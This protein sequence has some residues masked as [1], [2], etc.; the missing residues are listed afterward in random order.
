MAQPAVSIII[1]TH[2]RLR[3]L[4]AALDS[5]AAQTFTDYEVIVVD[6]GSTEQIAEGIADHP[7]RPRVLRQPN[8]GPAAAR[9]RGIQAATAPL[10]AFLDSDD[11]WLP[12]MLERFVSALHA[13]RSHR[14]FYG[15]MSPIDADGRA[16]P[17]RTKPC[18]GGW[19][20]QR[21]FCSSFIHVPT[22]VCHKELLLEAG[23]FNESLPVCEDYDLWL[24]L[25]VDHSFGLIDEPLA[26]RRLHDNRLSKSRMSRNLTVKAAMLKRFYS[27]EKAAGKLERG[28]AERRLARVCF[29][30]ARAAVRNGEHHTALEHLRDSRRFGRSSLRL[31]PWKICAGLLSVIRPQPAPQASPAVPG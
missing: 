22:V 25:S 6:D 23:G 8:L 11:L 17:G 30:A 12:T 31:L 28:S 29:A 27:C 10:L 4:L 19:I 15:P 1:P 16:V 3:L 26:L 20:T 24:R 13:D 2:D 14:I 18:Q 7:T 9:N 21:L 5:V